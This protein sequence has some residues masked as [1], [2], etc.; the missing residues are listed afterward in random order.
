MRTWLVKCISLGWD[1]LNLTETVLRHLELKKKKKI[2]SK[3]IAGLKLGLNMVRIFDSMQVFTK[4]SM[5][6]KLRG[7]SIQMCFI[8]LF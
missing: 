5:G 6:E 8:P 3:L 2:V 4:A 7:Q 1:C